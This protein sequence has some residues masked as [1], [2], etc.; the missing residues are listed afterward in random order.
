MK[1]CL[2]N[3]NVNP[4]FKDFLRAEIQAGLIYLAAVLEANGHEVEIVDLN[5]LIMEEGWKV[6][7]RIFGKTARRAATTGAG[8]IGINTRSDSFPTAIN[9][10]K[11]VKKILPNTPIIL[12]GLKVTCL[13]RETLDAF[14][15]IDFVL[16]GEAE[17]SLLELVNALEKGGSLKGVRGLTFR[18]N[19]RVIEN[20]DAVFPQD[21]DLLPLPAYSHY[22]NQLTGW[23]DFYQRQIY[24]NTGRG[25]PFDC[26]Y[27]S[28][29]RVYKKSYRLKSPGK[30]ME[31]MLMLNER[32]GVY[33]FS[34]GL[35][36][37]FAKREHV[38]KICEHI[39]KNK[40]DISWNCMAPPQYLDEELIATMKEHGCTSIAVGIETCSGRIQKSPQ[41][42]ELKEKILSVM[43]LCEKYGIFLMAFF[44]IGFPDETEDDINSTLRLAIDCNK[45]FKVFTLLDIFA[46]V[47][48]SALYYKI[49]DKLVWTG[50]LSGLA[51]GAT[52]NI[53]ANK[54]LVRKF[55]ELFSEF[56]NPPL[57]DMSHRLLYET[58]R[59]YH[60]SLPSFP[61]SLK[62]ALD[63]LKIEP[64]EFFR[65]FRHWAKKKKIFRDRTF[66]PTFIDIQKL[67]PEFLKNAYC[68]AHIPFVF[69]DRILRTELK[70]ARIK[71]ENAKEFVDTL[72]E[73]RGAPLMERLLSHNVK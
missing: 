42:K 3:T 30:I 60:N 9:I 49:K 32:Y 16:R 71:V 18:K 17:Y 38:L 21:L 34:M 22:E 23:K 12:G 35:T 27:C 13:G 48:G 29:P 10:A 40:L 8:L 4:G 67:L 66:L 1:V 39:R 65:R 33:R 70:S 28:S 37:I 68:D 61:L 25:C 19:G 58:V 73:E 15:F 36:H 2:V 6:D 14:P 55:P 62:I 41:K 26:K 44:S 20:P 57:P 64:V 52:A 51:K 47:S 54:K 46:T 24:T 11:A 69:I 59:F 5:L 7:G 43:A 31:E 72:G 56:Y 63:E 45:Y 50:F 53:P